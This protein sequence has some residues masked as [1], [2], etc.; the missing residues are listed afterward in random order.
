MTP[1]PITI[2]FLLFRINFAKASPVRPFPPRLFGRQPV[3]YNG[4][5]NVSAP[6]LY[7][8]STDDYFS[9]YFTEMLA[10]ANGGGSATSEVLRAISQI[11]PGDYESVYNEFNYLAD[12]IHNVA[13]SVDAT[14][15]P[16]SAREAHF[17]ASSYYRAAD[18]FLH[19]N[20]SDPRIYSLWDSALS[21]FDSAISLL[22]IPG[23]RVNV[24][25]ISEKGVKFTVPITFYKA[26]RDCTNVPTL[27]VGN[28]YDA[29]QE[30]SYHYIGLEALARGWN[31]A[32]Y[33]GP[34]Q[35][36]VRRQQQ[37]GF[38]PD[39]WNVVK[40]AVSYLISR[41]DVDSSRIAL[42]GI[43]FGGLLAPLAASREPRIAAVIAVDGLKNMS[44]AITSQVPSYMIEPFIEGNATAFDTLWNE[45]EVSP[46]VPMELRWLIAPSKWS[47]NTNSTFDW[48]T[49]LN[50][51]AVTPEVA[52]DINIPVFLAKGEDDTLTT[53]QPEQVQALFTQAGKNVTFHE[54]TTDLGAGEHCSLGAEPQI[55]QVILDWLHE[56]F[57]NVRD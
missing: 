1:L 34:G 52:K 25:A 24:S 5:S 51:F 21:D 37:L 48:L 41:D 7:P 49:R 2:L 32:T 47:F 42:M 4:A 39:W 46:S 6:A 56:V 36:T 3:A 27:L 11:R 44:D 38:I 14:K 12:A 33:E 50:Q 23:E 54:F 22:D 40:P 28:G 17:R 16:V 55:A 53:T 30:D 26:E 9:F 8:L 45:L 18:F 29:A 31:V 20:T 19:G 57:E 43:S 13:T 15:N 10:L 35:P